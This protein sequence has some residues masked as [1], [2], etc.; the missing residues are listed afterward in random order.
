MKADAAMT[1]MAVQA[2]DYTPKVDGRSIDGLDWELV[3]GALGAVR[4][5]GADLLRAMYGGDHRALR[6]VLAR[7]KGAMLGKM[8]LDRAGDVAERMVRDFVIPPHC[9]ACGGHGSRIIAALLVACPSCAGVGLRP[10]KAMRDDE[11]EAY[12]LLRRWHDSA[13]AIVWLQINDECG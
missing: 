2:V 5:P 6:V 12:D 8:D 3:A 4:H 1:Y 9:T 7:L 10:H 13:S 11:Q